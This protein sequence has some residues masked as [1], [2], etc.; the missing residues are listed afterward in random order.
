MKTAKKTVNKTTKKSPVEK[1]ADLQRLANLS[2]AEIDAHPLLDRYQQRLCKSFRNAAKRDR[3]GFTML[4]F[5]EV[6]LRATGN[7]YAAV[8]DRGGREAARRDGD[9]RKAAILYVYEALK[10]GPNIVTET[11]AERGTL[12]DL[13]L[14]ASHL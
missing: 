5:A 9:H 10:A 4:E 3:S 2:D 6:V 7:D 14:L 11:I 1:K 8:T 13:E 12:R